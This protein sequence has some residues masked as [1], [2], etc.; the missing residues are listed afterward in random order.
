LPAIKI[1][2]GRASMAARLSNM[3][4]A[5]G[6]EGSANK[7]GIGII[8]HDESRKIPAIVLANIRD[9]YITPPGQGFLP[10]DTAQHHRD[11]ILAVLGKALKEAKVTPEDID[12]ICFTKGQYSPV[13]DLVH[14]NTYQ[15]SSFQVREW[16]HRSPLLPL[17]R[18]RSL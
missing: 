1:S 17:L 3:P 15:P 2:I 6:L 13:C 9:T 10:R 7:L 11:C 14:Y 12:V 16:E 8:Q 4:I 5:L 18:E